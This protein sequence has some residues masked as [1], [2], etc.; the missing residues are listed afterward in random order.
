MPMNRALYVL[1][2]GGKFHREHCLGEQF[3]GHGATNVHTQ[4]FVVILGRNDF[5]QPG[6]LL[7]SFRP[8]VRSV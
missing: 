4:Y 3:A 7:E 2:A 6:G 8:A 1:R 5:H